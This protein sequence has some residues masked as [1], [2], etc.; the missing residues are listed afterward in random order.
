[1]Q[2]NTRDDRKR[3]WEVIDR[4]TG[5][6]GIHRINGNTMRKPA[7]SASTIQNRS[8]NIQSAFSYIIWDP[9]HMYNAVTNGWKDFEHQITFDVRQPKHI[10]IPWSVCANTVQSIR[11]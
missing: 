6:S 11:M 2:V 3:W 5:A 10:S 4:S 9:V 8:M 1:M 7:V